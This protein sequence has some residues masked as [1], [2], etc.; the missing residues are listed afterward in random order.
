MAVVRDARYG[1]FSFGP[2]VDGDFIPAVPAVSFRDGNYDHN[3]T[4]MIGH[5][6]DEGILFTPANATDITTF[7]DL[8][9]ALYPS[10]TRE[11]LDHVTETLYPAVF[12]GTH[13]YTDPYGRASNIRADVII[14]CKKLPLLNTFPQNA[15]SYQ[16]SLPPGI[17]GADL[18][19]TFYNDEGQRPFD[20]VTLSGVASEQAAHTHQRWIGDFVTRG[21]PKNINSFSSLLYPGHQFNAYTVNLDIISASV[22][23]EY[24]A[25]PRCE[26]WVSLEL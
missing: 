14:V 26:F 6:P 22:I 5:N 4:I 2:A 9:L 10:M 23:R 3:V 15:Y 17:H 24:A 16:F 8:V 18:E 21:Q 1:T 11:N 20:P 19:Y 25:G 13:G 7:A 12:D